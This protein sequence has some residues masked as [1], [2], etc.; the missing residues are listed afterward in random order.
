MARVVL[1]GSP[2]FALPSFEA[3]LAA[4]HEVPLVLS[5]PARPAGRGRKPRPTAVAAWALERGLPL[6]TPE[7]LRDAALRE[8]LAA[9]EPDLFAVVAYRI[10]PP[11]LIAVPRLGAVNLH[12][13]LLPEWRGA[14]P[15]QRALM[16]GAARSGLTVFRIEKGVDTGLL[17][18]QAELAVGP[19]E[20]AGELHD[21]MMAAG[22]PLLAGAVAELLAGRVLGRAQ[23]GGDWPPAPKLG[24]AD[25]IF[26]PAGTAGDLHDRVRALSPVPGALARF[27]G[28]PLKLLRTG[29]LDGPA[30][31]PPGELRAEGKRLTLACGSGRLELLELASAG[32]RALPAGDWLNG[33]HLNPGERLERP[34]HP[35]AEEVG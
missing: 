32:R 9:L 19:D 24:P 33:N 21:R 30:E 12:A 26:D 5:Q 2:E 1:M 16:A 34:A 8:R 6:E 18:A 31:G 35:A 14:A 15:I 20:T 22:A 29:R 10:L 23:P 25:R 17:L 27:R 11:S 4:G 28:E 3:L 13:S 7:K